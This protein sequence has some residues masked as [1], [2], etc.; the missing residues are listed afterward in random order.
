MVTPNPPPLGGQ[1]P[2]SMVLQDVKTAFLETATTIR[3]SSPF[4]VGVCQERANLP[5]KVQN[6]RIGSKAHF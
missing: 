5:G 6:S 2:A 1:H 4:T 3:A